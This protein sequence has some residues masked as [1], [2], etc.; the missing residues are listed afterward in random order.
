MMKN[1]QGYAN[2]TYQQVGFRCEQDRKEGKVNPQGQCLG[3]SS[4]WCL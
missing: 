4:Q 1:K 2:R 3:K